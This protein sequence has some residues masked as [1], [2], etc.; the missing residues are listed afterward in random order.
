[1]FQK[2]KKG[3]REAREFMAR[4]RRMRGKKRRTNPLNQKET[5]ASLRDGV[6]DLRWAG[7]DLR[8]R[9]YKSAAMHAGMASAT[10]RAVLEHAEYSGDRYKG[11]HLADLGLR[12]STRALAG[13]SRLKKNPPLLVLGN[14]GKKRRRPVLRKRN[15]S[16]GDCPKGFPMR[17][18]RDP[19]FQRE[20][21]V[22]R[23]RHGSHVPVKIT[24][25]RMP[26]GSPRFMTA[27]GHAPFAVYDAPKQSKRGK[28]KHV[29]GKKGKNR[30]LLVSSVSR[31]PRWLGYAGGTFKAKTK[32]LY[33]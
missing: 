23:S 6:Q 19:Q 20:L 5:Q 32:W 14:P 16:V 12:A 15:P 9:R 7:R 10:G 29:F 11:A 26:P 22:F 1:M 33:D 3:S 8:K 30:P 17:I 31:G 21:K 27:Y 2:F 24:P 13:K 4:L 28:F 18:W 25:V